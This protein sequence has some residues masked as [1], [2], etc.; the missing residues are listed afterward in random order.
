MAH[1]EL[2]RG[3]VALVSDDDLERISLHKWNAAWNPKTRSFYAQSNTPD[4]KRRQ[5]TLIMHREIMRA[6]VGQFVDHINRNTL[7]NRREN[8]RLCSFAENLRNRNLQSNNTS[9]FK[10][11]KRHAQCD[12]W[13]AT[14]SLNGVRRYLGLFKDPVEAARAYDREAK[15]LHGEF[16]STNE[17]LGLL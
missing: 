12:R 9:G 1:I 3:K 17:S 4:G 16:A 5:R 7:D 10:G 15:I 13:M 11:V 6:T 14:V 8:L 2:T